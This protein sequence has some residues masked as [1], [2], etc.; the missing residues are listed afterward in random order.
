[1]KFVEGTAQQFCSSWLMRSNLI[2]FRNVCFIYGFYKKILFE[3]VEQS[4]RRKNAKMTVAEWNENFFKFHFFFL[5]FIFFKRSP[6]YMHFFFVFFF[7]LIFFLVLLA[8]TSPKFLSLC[9][10]V[11]NTLENKFLLLLSAVVYRKVPIFMSYI[12]QIMTLV[13]RIIYKN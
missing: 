13:H 9:H 2:S 4:L 8:S 10:L 12:H 5:P 3:I 1:M 6:K 7:Q 11:G